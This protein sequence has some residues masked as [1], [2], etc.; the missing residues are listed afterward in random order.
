M[1]ANMLTHG[2]SRQPMYRSWDA[3]IQRCTNPNNNSWHNYGARG[4]R[5]CE[6]WMRSFAD[7]LADMGPRPEGHTIERLDND[8]NYEPS[9][10]VWLSRTGQ[11][12]N[13][14]NKPSRLRGSSKVSPEVPA[15]GLVL[16]SA[17]HGENA[18]M[19]RVPSTMTRVELQAWR[20]DYALTFTDAAH[21]LGVSRRQLA[22]YCSGQYA[23]PLTV[24]IL[25]TAYDLLSARRRRELMELTKPE[26]MEK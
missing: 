3:M 8:G 26:H 10:C 25:V 4:I 14:R 24:A 11:A 13:R 5:V 9:N 20:A 6:R 1:E 22:S 2:F 17:P 23:I 15:P 19:Q 16:H 12:R 18:K 21:A 7:F